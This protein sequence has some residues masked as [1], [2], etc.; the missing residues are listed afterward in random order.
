[1]IA[2]HRR[3][4]HHDEA[5]GIKR[6]TE[7]RKAKPGQPGRP[8]FVSGDDKV[9]TG[10]DGREAGDEN[11]RRHRDDMRVCVGRAVGRVEGPSGIDPA[12]NERPKSKR[13]AENKEIPAHEI[14]SGKSDIAR[15]QHHGQDKIT[16]HRRNRRD[17]KK[18]DHE[19][20]MDGEELVVSLGGDEVTLRRQ[21]FDPHHGCGHAR[22]EE[23]DD[24]R[25]KVKN[26]DAFMIG[27]QQPRPHAMVPAQVIDG[28]HFPRGPKNSRRR[29]FHF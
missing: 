11:S 10:Q 28:R 15:P 7:E 12:M 1:M 5:G 23:K 19:D 29:T 21:E 20:A 22:D 8:H 27:R 3:R 26:P 6:P 17:E 24:D 4:Q 18:P 16:Q 13:S 2:K 14:E 25:P 9:E